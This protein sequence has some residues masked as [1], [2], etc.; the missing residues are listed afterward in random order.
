L[1]HAPLVADDD[2]GRVQLEQALE[3]VVA[4]DHAAIQIVQIAR[5]ETATVERY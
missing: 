3:A 4:I 2:L 5:R 1:Q